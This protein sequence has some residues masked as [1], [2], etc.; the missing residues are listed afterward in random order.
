MK[1][2]PLKKQKQKKVVMLI[3]ELGQKAKGTSCVVIIF[4]LLHLLNQLLFFIKIN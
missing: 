2:V 3:M 1:K 4:L